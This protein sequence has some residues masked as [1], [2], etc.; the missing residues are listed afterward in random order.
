MYKVLK[1][2]PKMVQ[3][4]K[5]DH[6]NL[7]LGLDSL[8]LLGVPVT[9]VQDITMQRMNRKINYPSPNFDNLRLF[10]DKD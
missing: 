3:M 9:A 5:G 10:C 2:N 7:L 4:P 8:N 1:I 6:I